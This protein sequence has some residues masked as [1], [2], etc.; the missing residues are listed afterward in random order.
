VTMEKRKSEIANRKAANENFEWHSEAED[1]ALWA[2]ETPVAAWPSRRRSWRLALLLLTAV[3]LMTAFVYYRLSQRVSQAE[4]AVEGEV[5]AAFNLLRQAAARGDAELVES[6]LLDYELPGARSRQLFEEFIASGLFYDRS[7]LGLTLLPGE[8]RIVALTLSP[9]LNQAEL[10]WQQ[11]YAYLAAQGLTETISLEFEAIYEQRDG[12][13]LQRQPDD[14]YWGEWQTYNGRALTLGYLE[15]DRAIA[16]RLAH[17]LDELVLHLCAGGS[18]V[19]LCPE[20]RPLRLRLDSLPASLQSMYN[21][22]QSFAFGSGTTRG[23][24]SANEL[25]TPTLVGLPVDEAGYQALYRGYARYLLGTMAHH[26]VSRAQQPGPFDWARLEQQLVETGLRPWPPLEPTAAP[27]TAAYRLALACATP[28]GVDLVAYDPATAAW[29]RLLPDLPLTRITS[30]PDGKGLI[31]QME[32]AAAS[33]SGAASLASEGLTLDAAGQANMTVQWWLYRQG[34][35]HLLHEWALPFPQAEAWLAVAP[36]DPVRLLFQLQEERLGGERSH[37]LA[38][39]EQCAAG[40]CRLRSLPGYMQWSAD[41]RHAFLVRFDRGAGGLQFFLTDGE[42]QIIQEIGANGGPF[43]LDNETYGYTTWSRNPG[44]ATVMVGV[45][46]QPGAS[47]LLSVADLLP[48]LPDEE[49]AAAPFLVA[50][51]AARAGE[52]ELLLYAYSFDT[53]A[54]EWPIEHRYTFGLRLAADARQVEAMKLL[55]RGDVYESALQLSLNG[56]WLTRLFYGNATGNWMVEIEEWEEERPWR[57]ELG[58]HYSLRAYPPS[59]SWSPDGRWLLIA[60]DGLFYLLDPE[61]QE[62]RL[63]VPETAS[64]TWPTWVE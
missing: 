38:D 47:H 7:A 59:Y 26:N 25:P 31:L 43:W 61:S 46:G 42:G 48:L 44:S 55:H 13:W 1:E 56:R 6:L 32:D 23:N 54:G 10:R 11:D 5:L 3:L 9:D 14:D 24:L 16:E 36:G 4:A 39:L 8:P 19:F 57:F 51:Y 40:D 62:H 58:S 35:P 15:R 53:T 45:V 30:L 64:C 34:E 63:I 60:H 12:R 17:D 20:L 29:Q 18:P 2:D 21:V 49:A 52:R 27:W 37:Y 22:Q 33:L 41:G 28:R 50:H